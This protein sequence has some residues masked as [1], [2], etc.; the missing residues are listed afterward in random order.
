M[1]PWVTNVLN[2]LPNVITK[3]S[4]HKVIFWRDPVG[5]VDA[6]PLRCSSSNPL[7]ENW[8]E[9]MRKMREQVWG[10]VTRTHDQMTLDFYKNAKPFHLEPGDRVWVKNLPHEKNKLD[11]L[12]TGPC[13]VL[14]HH[15]GTGKYSVA[16]PDGIQD[17]HIERLKLYLPRSDGKII[18]LMYY[19]PQPEIPHDDGYVVEKIIGHRMRAGERQ[20]LV[21][22]R[23]YDDTHNTWEP[24]RNFIGFIQKDWSDY[25]RRHGLS[26]PV[27]KI[28][29]RDEEM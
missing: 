7:A 10:R 19:Q 4:A 23:G 8:M 3:L 14:A 24:A 1:L 6:L 5:L 26:V 20:W 21:K 22:W 15:R 29:P 28:M 11:A 27:E 18:P 16:L 2:D 25:N 17:V 12:Y 13:E 9:D